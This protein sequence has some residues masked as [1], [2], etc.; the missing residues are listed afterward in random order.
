MPEKG[1]SHPWD[2]LTVFL[3]DLRVYMR[4]IPEAVKKEHGI[5]PQCFLSDFYCCILLKINFRW[6]D[7]EKKVSVS[8]QMGLTVNWVVL[9]PVCGI[10]YTYA[11]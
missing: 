2:N 3:T 1:F 11:V 10:S 7:I 8:N 6:I 4:N 5:F 9:D